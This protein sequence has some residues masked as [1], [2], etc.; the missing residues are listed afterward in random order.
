[1]GHG[2]LKLVVV[3]RTGLG[4]LPGLNLRASWSVLVSQGPGGTFYI[5]DVSE[6]SARSVWRVINWITRLRENREVGGMGCH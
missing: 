4:K 1:M 3:C 6:Q 2:A 5:C